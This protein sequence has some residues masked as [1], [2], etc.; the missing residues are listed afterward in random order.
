[1]Y[2]SCFAFRLSSY[3]VK[4]ENKRLVQIQVQRNVDASSELKVFTIVN[5]VIQ[6]IYIYLYWFAFHQ[7]D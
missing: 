7:S 4:D 5:N 2:L 3:T 6:C 1:M